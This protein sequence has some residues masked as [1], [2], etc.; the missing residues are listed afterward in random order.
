M[1]LAS[2][3]SIGRVRGIEIRIHWSWLI[4]ASLLTWALADGLFGDLFEEWNAQ[5]RWLAAFATALLFFGSVLMHELSHAIV[6][7]WHGVRVPSIT[8]FVFGGV[9]AMGDEMRSAGEEFRIAVAGPLMSWA[10]AVGFGGVWL[11]LGD[12]ELG[13]MFGYLALINFALGAFNLLPGFPLDGGRV[14]RS[15]VWARTGDLVR[16]T[17]IASQVGGA[18]AWVM[19]I[20]GL[21]NVL[22]FGL[23]GGIWYVLIGLF[24][25][26][27]ARGSYESVVT[28]RALKDMRVG[29][30]MRSPPEPVPAGMAIA[31]LVEG[32]V[33]RTSERAF[34]VGEGERVVGIL[35]ISDIQR[36]PREQWATTAVERAMVPA[37]RVH[38]LGP[39]TPLLEALRL[40]Q[41][42]D[43]HQLPVLRDGELVGLLTRGDVM[44]RIEFTVRYT[45]PSD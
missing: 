12:R 19:I 8:L 10:L 23:V 44:R 17:R 20:G 40:M 24:L 3:V 29:G 28:D 43:V 31:G 30:A 2:G 7:Q 16:A 41:E 32:R 21:L 37:E 9:S 33:L 5:Q 26:T 34:L 4:I 25:R 18:L 35:T 1:N 27:A 45:E 14:F 42:H 36:I 22:W 15:A 13:A 39:E 38:T 6:A 11:L